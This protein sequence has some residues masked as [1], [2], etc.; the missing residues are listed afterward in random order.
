MPKNFCLE[1]NY[2]ESAQCLATL[3]ERLASSSRRASRRQF[4]EGRSLRVLD[5]YNDFATI[6]RCSP[7][8]ALVLAAEYDKIRA[9]HPWNIPVI[10]I[11]KWRPELLA[12][13]GEIGFFRLLDINAVEPVPT[14]RGDKILQFQTGKFVARDEAA[15]LTDAL[16]S[17]LVS[18]KPSLEADIKFEETLMQ[19]LG[20]IQEATENSCDH[21]YRDTKIEDANRRWWATGAISFSEHHLNLVVYDQGNS[22]PATL[23]SWEKYPFVSSRLARF[24]RLFGQLVGED[25]LDAIKMRLA[26]DAPRSSTGEGHRGKGFV[27][28]KDVVEQSRDARLRILSRRGEFIY[29][30][31]GKKASNALKTPLNGTLVEWD[32]W[33]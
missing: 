18:A 3:R 10:D 29:R 17:L 16:K 14:A 6:E 30:K 11:N 27:L 31:G 9:L 25:E 28:F 1:Q 19:L 5:G 8:A 20:A 15:A 13:L 33:L 32:L 4:K 22:I 21:A 23:P 12:Q 7:S 2:E 26:M 24:R